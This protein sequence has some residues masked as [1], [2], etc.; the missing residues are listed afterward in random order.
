MNTAVRAVARLG[1]D[2]GHTMLAVRNGF[3]GLIDGNINELSW[4]SISGWVSKGGAE[5]GTRRYIPAGG[6]FY[7]IA[8]NL[9][10]YEVDGLLIIGGWAGYEG[11]YQ[12]F[13]R[14]NDF[15]SF[16]IPILCL[17]ASIDNNLPGSDLSIGSD[18]ALNNIVT[19]VDK[20][21]QSAVASKRC[22]VVE[23]MGRD[24][25]Y[26]ALLSGLA[27]GA[28]KA[29]LPEEGISLA[30]LQADVADLIQGFQGGKRLG[31]MIRN[32][33]AGAQYDTNFISTLFE[34]EGG[35][36]FD[37]RQAILGHIQ[38][39]GSP[40]PFDRVQATRL[41]A[42]CIEFLID[43]VD[44]PTPAAA[45]I[46][47]KGGEMEFTSLYDAWSNLDFSAPKINGGCACAP[48]PPRWTGTKHHS[49]SNVN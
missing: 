4:M 6:D 37:V 48:L 45:A 32:E 23:V 5:L 40:S 34:Q 22:F 28:E 42:R 41:A 26:L 46:G 12:L 17:P 38:Q 13:S 2:K 30:E 20:I 33:K 16:N 47:L 44:K 21:K 7:A 8:K 36:L 25:G 49:A 11:A 35:G 10:K 24:C 43:E 1:I 14:R 9:D 19:N 29:Y 27:T 15:N 18:T 3:R 31:L 39:G